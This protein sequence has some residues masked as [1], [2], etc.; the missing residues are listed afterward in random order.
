MQGHR[1]NG[2]YRLFNYGQFPVILVV[3]FAMIR[4]SSGYSTH[5][6]VQLAVSTGLIDVLMLRM[7]RRWNIVNIGAVVV[8]NFLALSVIRFGNDTM[9]QKV[10]EWYVFC[11]LL[12]TLTNINLKQAPE[13]SAGRRE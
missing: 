1:R 4:Y 7:S 9:E 5:P 12:I 3:T 13:T 10:A 2:W 6:G 11:A 8:L